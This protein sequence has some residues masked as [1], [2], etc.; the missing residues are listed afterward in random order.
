MPDDNSTIARDFVCTS[1]NNGK[2]H[3]QK[4]KEKMAQLHTTPPRFLGQNSEQSNDQHPEL[5]DIAV[6]S[7]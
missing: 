7:I 6:I 5:I 2:A 4:S 3:K 1:R